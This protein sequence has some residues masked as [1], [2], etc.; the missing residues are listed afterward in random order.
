MGAPRGGAPLLPTAAGGG[1]AEGG[2]GPPWGAAAG[3]AACG[4]L[5]GAAAAAAAGGALGGG[6]PGSAEAALWQLARADRAYHRKRG[7][8]AAAAAARQGRIDAWSRAQREGGR[9]DAATDGAGGAGGGEVAERGGADREGGAFGDTLLAEPAEALAG[10]MEPEEVGFASWSRR[11]AGGAS[12]APPREPLRL[13]EELP[14]LKIYVYKLPRKFNWDLSKRYKRCASDQY[15]TEV[16]FH[17]VIFNSKTLRTEDPAEADFFYMPVYA[18]CFLWV[19]SALKKLPRE[20]AFGE[21]NALMLEALGIIRQE[22]HW[23]KS[24]GRDH[25]FLWPGA[26]GPT[27]FNDWEKEIKHSIYLT[28]EGDRKVDYF[29][30]WKDVVIPGMEFDPK[31]YSVPSRKALVESVGEKRKYLAFFRGTIHHPEGDIYSKG[32][33]P[34]LEKL[35]EG[36]EDIIYDKRVKKCDRAC[37]HDEMGNSKFCLNPLGW[38]PWTLRFYQALMTRCVPVVIADNIEFPYENEVDYTS[39]V[40]K[41]PEKDVDNIEQTLRNMPDE[42]LER[43]RRVMDDIWLSYTYQR[44]PQSGDAFHFVLQE[45]A[46][47]RKRFRNSRGATWGA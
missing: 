24:G 37:Y 26:R 44:P 4:L 38:T 10:L 6:W 11:T 28:P 20:Q 14:P 23:A 19:K 27:I 39:F 2:C 42:E 41:I 12:P 16:F 22:G 30:T 35:F 15:G 5:L 45:L 1:P 32:L 17:E 25:F 18:E 9:R 3:W 31:F 36:K 47:K 33:R 46:R 29:N 43:R 8:L 21:T 13:N 40:V 7:E 34:K